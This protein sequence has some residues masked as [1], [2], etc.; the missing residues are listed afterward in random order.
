MSIE[1]FPHNVVRNLR[2]HIAVCPV[3]SCHV[4]GNSCHFDIA[5]NVYCQRTRADVFLHMTRVAK[6]E[7]EEEEE[8][9]TFSEGLNQE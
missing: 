2:T 3:V 8:E 5:L 6:E 9:V 4:I 1:P 7:E